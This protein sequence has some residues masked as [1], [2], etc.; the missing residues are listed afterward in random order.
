MIVALFFYC[1][2][3]RV[4]TRVNIRV[5]NE[6]RVFGK[7]HQKICFPYENVCRLRFGEALGYKS[8]FVD[9]IAANALLS[10]VWKRIHNS[11]LCIDNILQRKA[12]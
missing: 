8:L 4:N 11:E 7:G 10:P 3:V 6:S 1:R 9:E 5:L 12:Q 2:N